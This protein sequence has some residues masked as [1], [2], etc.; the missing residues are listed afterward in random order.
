MFSHAALVFSTIDE[1][2][3]NQ[4]QSRAI[5]T[6]NYALSRFN[7]GTLETNCDDGSIVAGA[8][9][10][11]ADE[12]LMSLLT[13]AVYLYA[14][15]GNN[16]YQQFFQDHYQTVGPLANN[17]WGGDVLYQQDAYLYYLNLSNVNTAIQQNIRS[18]ATNAVNNNWNGFF[19]WQ[20]NDLYRSF[21][22]SW[23][24]YWGSNRPK[25]NYAA[26]NLS[27]ALQDLGDDAPSLVRKG[28]EHLHYFHGLNP[29]GMVMLSNMYSLGG[30]RCVNEIYHTWFYDQT[31]YDHALTS[32]KGPAPGYVTGGPNP[33]FSV[34]SLSPPANQ[35]TLKS[36]LEFNDGYPL[37][38]W[39]ITEPSISY[40]AAYLR[41][42]AHFVDAEGLVNNTR[43][44]AFTP[45]AVEVFPN[46]AQKNIRIDLP[47]GNYTLQILDTT[48]K[49]VTQQK[50]TAG[51]LLDIQQL[52]RGSYL[53]NL[54]HLESEQRYQAKLVK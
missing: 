29:L 48:G 46:P 14:L 42:L 41:L 38:S 54:K 19:G 3:A 53:L 49:L 36:Y 35:P 33:G 26:L 43:T 34:T 5:Q 23:S 40:Q 22:P 11:S 28:T 6:F 27:L 30:D 21:M 4:L 47:E 39:E 25:A 52:P 8:A 12:Q 32:E 2:Y 51:T 20:E 45:T 13:A 16:T 17:Y 9:D 15:T 24:Y 7:V 44:S 31:E 50:Y 10:R 1:A 18:S 37:S